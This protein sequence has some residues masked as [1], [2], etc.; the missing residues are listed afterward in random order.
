MNNLISIIVTAA[1]EP[2]TVRKCIRFLLDPEINGLKGK[3]DIQLELITVIPDT[4][5]NKE[6]EKE[7]NTYKNN[8]VSWKKIIDPWKGKPTALNSAFKQAKG[9]YLVLTDGDVFFTKNSLFNLL[10]KILKNNLYLGV[11]GKPISQ[12]NRGNFWVYIGHLLAEAANHKREQTLIK[13]KQFF[14]MSGYIM[15]IK[16]IH[17]KIPVDCL[18]DDAYI[19]YAILKEN[20]SIAY[21][22]TACVYV[23]YPKN[24]KDW[25]NQKS[26]SVGGYMQLWTYG[27]VTPKTK[28][29]NIWKELEYFYFPIKFARNFKELIW[30]V[31]LYPL[32]F[33]LWLRI[34]WEQKILKKE[35]YKTWV[36]I[37]STK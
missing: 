33:Y 37:E 27:I 23:K 20:G 31:Y 15:V 22:P 21:E 4:E 14:V 2:K 12:D 18:S 8:I 30:S 9:S 6:A 1:N 25:F 36:R 19:S 34:F 13:K 28:V 7:I 24:I 32:R 16:N 5:T 11:T 26:R 3:K 10:N 29:R 35:F 17:L